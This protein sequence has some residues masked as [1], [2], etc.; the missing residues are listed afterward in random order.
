MRLELREYQA[1][2]LARVDAAEARGVRAQLGVAATGLGK[3]VM[4][5]SLAERRQART[6]V[7][8]HRD[9]LVTQA[10]AKLL[11]V[12]PDLGATEAVHVAL[13]GAGLGDLARTVRV[14]P[15]GIGIVK[16]AADD[17]HAQ[18][19][20]A[21]VQTL[22]RPARL[23]R[24]TGAT[25][26]DA[27]AAGALWGGDHVE[28][29]DLVVVDEA[30]HATADS[31]RAV[32]DGLRAGH[33]ATDGCPVCEAIDG[34]TEDDHAFPDLVA[35]HAC[36]PTPAGPLLLG[37]TATPD[38]G[39]GKGL[40]DLFSEVVFSYDLLWGIRAGFLSDLRGKRVVVEQL[41]LSGVKVRR[42][43]YDAGAAGRALEDADAPQMIVAAWM[44]HALGRR[45]L[46]FTPTVE[47]ARLVA[48]QFAAVGVSAGFVHGGTPMDERRQLLQDYSSGAI[49]VLA[50]CAVLT[51]GYD[52]PRTD[53]IVV[54]RPTKS[55]ALYTQMVGRGTRRHPDKADCLVLDVV[56][57]SDVHSLVTVP[58]L[59]GL[60]GEYADR[61]GDGS[62]LLAGVAQDWDDEQ[63]R[64]GRMR[65]Q[66]AELFRKMRDQGIAWVPVHNE[67]APLKR[68]VRTLGKAADGTELPTVV[69]AQR[70]AEVWTAGLWWP[71]TKTEPER[72]AVLMAEV[73]LELAQGMAEDYVRKH[74]GGRLTDATASWRKGKPSPKAVAAAKKWRL[75]VDPK[76]SAG[77]LSEAL[78]A[79]IARIKARPKKGARR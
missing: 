13:H 60:G 74:G 39:D 58:S 61:L 42:G 8:A 33:P 38:R 4:F 56:G 35:A 50:N 69:L 9:E 26:R 44:E 21:S 46:V 48:V 71:A 43:D 63:V 47:V 53:C 65:A 34:T 2:A 24:L 40:D 31:Y 52:E 32:L 11:E 14:N 22:A 18:V 49:E 27:T 76:W 20:V 5:A 75:P 17:V 62:G 64:L 1:D 72:K 66:D 59:F 15:R 54:A 19:V 68:Y 36:G 3:T 41:D 23:A 30:H 6:L 10:A 12:W 67:G 37:V 77:E 16:A 55:R 29:F 78:D 73:H 57:A 7:L 45:T 70:D 51:E 25:E 79:H 28:P